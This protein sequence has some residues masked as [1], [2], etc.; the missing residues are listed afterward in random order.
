MR[1][2][3]LAALLAAAPLTAG[4][5]TVTRCTGPDG[6]LTFSNRGCARGDKAEALD[7]KAVA[8]DSQGLRDWAKRSPP[9]RAG[10]ERV[11]PRAEARP[12]RVRD[13]VACE[14]ARRDLRF[15]AGYTKGKHGR[16]G[17]LREEVRQA[18]GGS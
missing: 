5:E 8:A 18:C 3:L 13:A 17:A 6:H 12:T 7:L 11:R 2:M 4:A 10:S 15:E 1:P 16:I 14:N 9:A